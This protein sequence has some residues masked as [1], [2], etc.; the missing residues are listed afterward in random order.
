MDLN[1][2]DVYDINYYNDSSRAEL[3]PM[4][5]GFLHVLQGGKV[6]SAGTTVIGTYVDDSLVTAPSSHR[7]DAFFNDM[8]ILE[9]KYL[10]GFKIA[11]RASRDGRIGYAL[12]QK[13]TVAEMLT[14]FVLEDANWV[15]SPIGEEKSSLEDDGALPVIS[16]DADGLPSIR[17]FQS[18]VG[19]LLWVTW[20]IRP[21]IA[22]AAHRAT[23][24]CHAPTLLHWR[25]AKRIAHYIIGT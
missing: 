9:L 24:Q 7:V 22:F 10:G 18:L 13:S 17:N 8:Q 20:C 23:R 2:L 25:L 6:D 11:R 19:G 21:D 4:H 1:K 14:R 15:R 16:S 12:N 3:R 5:N